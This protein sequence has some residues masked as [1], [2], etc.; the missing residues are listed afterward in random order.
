MV[1]TSRTDSITLLLAVHGG[2]GAF[3]PAFAALALDRAGVERL[4]RAADVFRAGQE[5][6]AELYQ[7]TYFD[8]TPDFFE[9]GKVDE[10]WPTDEAGRIADLFEDEEYPSD[11]F[12][13]VTP[14]LPET[15]SVRLDYSRLI[16]AD[17]LNQNRPGQV[18]YR[19]EACVKHTDAEIYTDE[20]KEE[21]LRALLGRLA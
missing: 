3:G 20:L 1:T 2:G 7:T 4:L 6:A 15:G 11:G 9:S 21:D 5:L 14:G 18:D 19:W 8:Y 13:E 16:V 10:D 12:I 17:A